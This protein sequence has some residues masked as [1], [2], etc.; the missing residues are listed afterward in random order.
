[1]YSYKFYFALIFFCISA[2]LKA[3]NHSYSIHTI[4]FYNLEN[5]FD[6]INDPRKF[7]EYSP[8]M[9]VESNRSKIYQKKTSNMA[10]VISDIGFELTKNSPSI[11]GVC[12]IENK[13][14]LIDLIS[15][16][17]LKDKNYGIIH[18]DSPDARGI[19]VA[20]LYKKHIFTPTHSS[21][22]T[23]KLYDDEQEPIYT[24]D[25]L[26]VSGQLDGD[27]IHLLVN[28]WPSRRGGE[29]KSQPRRISAAKLTR[30]L[31]DSLQSIDPYAKV[32]IM[33]DFNDNPNNKSIKNIL[34]A[35]K[36]RNNLKIRHLYNPF[37]KL[38]TIGLGTTAYRD[39]WSLFDQIMISKPLLEKD[40]SSFQ[41]FKSGIYNKNYLIDNQGRYKGYPLRSFSDN[42]FNNGYSDHF[43][44]YIHLIKK[45]SD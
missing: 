12:E 36:N 45:V 44:V 20:L 30:H 25:Q 31:T 28:H 42:G 7:D 11:I 17:F 22:H 23:L 27:K 10:K 40:F 13:D 6:T 26:L 39:A 32:I 18:F 15:N 35:K 1:M 29:T 37:Y 19:D 41:Y 21:H 43:P 33:G 4:A 2:V 38:Y 8:I 3:Q 34:N 9:E 24:R 5:L 16:D 14:V